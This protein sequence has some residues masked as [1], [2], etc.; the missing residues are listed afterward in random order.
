MFLEEARLPYRI[1]PVNIGQGD[2]F[3]PEFLALSP[4]NRMPAIVD[5]QPT[6][7]GASVT[8]FESGA[9][10]LYLAEKTGKFLPTDLRS[11]L[12][13]IEWLMWQMGGVGPMFGQAYH[14]TRYAPENVPY[15]I[16]RYT[17]ESERLLGVLDRRLMGRPY[18]ADEY[19]IADMA[20]FPWVH[21]LSSLVSLDAYNHVQRWVDA[22]ATR[23][24][25]RL[26]LSIGSELRPTSPLE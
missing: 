25:T 19:S 21:A 3:R 2:Q 24:A 8:V 6:G 16:E 10:L 1:L 17:K 22:I 15:A 12:V 26:A 7:G 4:N 5:P 13:V 18:V 14:F 20:I 11:R 9:I 23:P